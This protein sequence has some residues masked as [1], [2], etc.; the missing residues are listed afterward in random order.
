MAKQVISH[1]EQTETIDTSIGK[2][3][4]FTEIAGG[5]VSVGCETTFC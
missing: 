3:V 2:V 4:Y 5:C 1:H